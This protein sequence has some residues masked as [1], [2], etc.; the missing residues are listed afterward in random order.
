VGDG[1]QNLSDRAAASQF[2]LNQRVV[3]HGLTSRPELTG[4]TA[5]VVGTYDAVAKRWPI[6]LDSGESSAVKDAN[7]YPSIFGGVVGT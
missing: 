5:A 6:K 3:L 7:L 4:A 1:E 2:V